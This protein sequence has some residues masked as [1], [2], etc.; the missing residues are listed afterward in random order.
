M[1]LL[2]FCFT[3]LG[4]LLGHKLHLVEVIQAKHVHAP[5]SPLGLLLVLLGSEEVCC[6]QL[7][8]LELRIKLFH[9]GF[10]PVPI[11]N[12]LNFLI[13]IVLIFIFVDYGIFALGSGVH[14][15]FSSLAC[16]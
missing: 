9:C 14:H 15:I 13:F 8:G 2:I 7:L 3:M 16:L 10:S 4:Q 6:D 11:R 5:L 1:F 12:S